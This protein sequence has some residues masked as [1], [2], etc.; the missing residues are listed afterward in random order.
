MVTKISPEKKEK[1]L[2]LLIEGKSWSIIEEKTGAGKSTI[3]KISKEL[4]DKY[5]HDVKDAIDTIKALKKSGLSVNNVVAGARVYSILSTMSLDDE[6]FYKFVSNVYKECKAID[7]IPS[8]LVEVSSNVIQLQSE[9]KI[10]IEKLVPYIHEL[11][12]QKKNLE[13]DISK[14]DEKKKNRVQETNEILT[15]AK[16]I[17]STLEEYCT[18]KEELKGYGADF[19]QMPKLANMLKNSSGYDYTIKEIV[20]K[21]QKQETL[22]AQIKGLQEQKKALETTVQSLQQNL[23]QAEQNYDTT[24][25]KL[26]ESKILYGHLENTI[27]II[28]NL[29]KNGINPLHISQWSSIIGS[30][31]VPAYNLEVELVKYSG[32]KSTISYLE[33]K[34]NNLKNEKAGLE[35]CIKT[36]TQQQEEIASSIW[37]TKEA[38][39]KTIEKTKSDA[40]HLISSFQKEAQSSME[41]LQAESSRNITNTAAAAQDGLQRIVTSLDDKIAEISRYSKS[42]GKLQSLRPLFDIMAGKKDGDP[43]EIYLAAS[44]YLGNFLKWLG[45][46]QRSIILYAKNLIQAIERE[47]RI[48]KNT[49]YPK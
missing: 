35:S 46:E 6:Q 14:L 42:F 39:I 25:K 33:T 13:L 49:R 10:N 1:I 31:N 8:K 17:E 20:D 23:K 19:D 48:L 11:I 43:L 15:N 30:S 44:S 21:L 47:A 38:A 4:E 5:G 45:P 7:L 18:I 2:Q 26:D 22:E 12:E 28:H 37:Q 29:E 41:L 27:K 9:S 34:S 36:L 40:E 16:V 3:Q 24:S 32:L